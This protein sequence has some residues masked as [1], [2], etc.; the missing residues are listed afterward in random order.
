MMEI[1]MV[2]MVL[3]L[4]IPNTN[5]LSLCLDTVQII[6]LTRFKLYNLNWFFHEFMAQEGVYEVLEF[7]NPK[8]TRKTPCLKF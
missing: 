8:Q 4:I 7:Y 5:R 6:V 3:E 2:N 1:R